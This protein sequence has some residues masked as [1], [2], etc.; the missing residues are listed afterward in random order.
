MKSQS[1][2]AWPARELKNPWKGLSAGTPKVRNPSV[3][4]P[5]LSQAASWAMKSVPAREPS[6][7]NCAPVL[8]PRAKVLSRKAHRK[9]TPKAIRRVARARDRPTRGPPRSRR[10]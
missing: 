10:W 6:S 1:T 2:Q 3:G 5:P 4:L 9:V 7:A 8:K